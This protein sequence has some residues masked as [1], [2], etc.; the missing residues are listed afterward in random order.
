MCWGGKHGNVIF[1]SQLRLS[2]IIKV[3]IVVIVAGADAK[4]SRRVCGVGW[5]GVGKGGEKG[6]GGK[7]ARY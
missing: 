7:E 5:G 1:R 4:R 2:L 3:V 6:G